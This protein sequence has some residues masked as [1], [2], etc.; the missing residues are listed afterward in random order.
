MIELCV[1]LLI[2]INRGFCKLRALAHMAHSNFFHKNCSAYR[3]AGAIRLNALFLSRNASDVT[4]RYLL[5]TNA[6][7]P[8]EIR[9]SIFCEG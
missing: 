2:V 1:H 7:F 3:H 5:R 9:E 8:S 6:T 4:M